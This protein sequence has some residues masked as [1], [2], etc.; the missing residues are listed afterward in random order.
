V[1]KKLRISDFLEVESNEKSF[2]WTWFYFRCTT[3]NCSWAFCSAFTGPPIHSIGIGAGIIGNTNITGKVSVDFK[4]LAKRMILFLQ[5]YCKLLV[6]V[7]LG[8]R[9]TSYPLSI[10]WRWRHKKYKDL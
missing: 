8:T 6:G 7:S 2:V 1:D 10:I 9:E 5:N 4:G 3:A